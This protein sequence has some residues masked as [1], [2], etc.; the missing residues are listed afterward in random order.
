MLVTSIFSFP[1]NPFYPSRN[2]FDYL[3]Y[4][5]FVV[6]KC[7]QFGQVYKILSSGTQLKLNINAEDILK[8][9]NASFQNK[10][11][12][13]SSAAEKQKSAMK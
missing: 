2:K 3:G 8:R 10:Y 11:F 9:E 13:R 1:H 12:Q 4:I 5:Y 7:F 6:C